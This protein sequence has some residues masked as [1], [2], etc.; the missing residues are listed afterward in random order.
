MYLTELGEVAAEAVERV[1]EEVGER[2]GT[3]KKLGKVGGMQGAGFDRGISRANPAVLRG[4][5]LLKRK[6]TFA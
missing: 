4:S 2:K 1:C 6:I 5:L 3:K